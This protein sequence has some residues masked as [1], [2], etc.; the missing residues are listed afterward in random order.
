MKRIL[1][2][3]LILFSTIK[4][5]AQIQKDVLAAVSSKD[6][7]A[8]EK[9]TET[10][11]NS[12]KRI[13]SYW[14]YRRELTKGYQEGIFYF[15]KSIPDKTNPDICTVNM[16]RL[17]LLTSGND[18][19]YYN[20]C[21]AKRDMMN[22]NFSAPSASIYMY[23]N[24]TAFRKLKVNFQKI[25]GASLNEK[26]LFNENIVY[27]QLC[28]Y[29]GTPP[30]KKVEI[31]LIVQKRDRTSLMKWLQSTNTEAQIYAINGYFQLKE[32]GLKITDEELK[33]IRY[34]MRKKGDI[35]SCG[36]CMRS[37]EKISSAIRVFKF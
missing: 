21:K 18:I 33:I 30:E 28:G 4:L 19:I 22:G 24:D 37:N 10:L 7:A 27:G 6:F 9:Y 29:G 17:T 15:E 35:I 1:I 25:Y 32:L 36:G 11:T 12:K 5:S 31:D 20:I 14:E 8:F 13:N 23:K 34:V 2:L 3:L 16:Y 26:E